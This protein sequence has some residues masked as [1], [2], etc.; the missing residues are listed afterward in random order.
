M[1]DDTDPSKPPIETPAPTKLTTTKQRW[2]REGR[3]LTGRSARPES[4]RLPPGQHIVKDWPV[5]DLGVQPDIARDRWRLD[6]FGAVERPAVWDWPTFQAQTQTH[7]VTD[8]HCVTS[9]SRYDNAWDGVA[10]LD[11]L[12]AVDPKPEAAFVVLHS[13]DGYTTNVPL[14]D[15]AAPDALLAHTW[16]GQPLSREHGGPVRLVIPH[17]YFWKSAKWLQRIEFA[18]EDRPSF[19]ETRGYHNRG[20]PWTEQRY[21]EDG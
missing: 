16:Q 13:Y 5:L 7:E 12:A 15:F 10:T 11:I 9:W 4:E 3:F 18:I 21:S 2:A 20:D 1:T 19:W 8:I 14:P 6:I 17:L